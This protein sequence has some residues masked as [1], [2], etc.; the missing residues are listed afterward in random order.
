M[1]HFRV[2]QHWKKNKTAFEK[3]R[4]S[5]AVK[6]IPNPKLAMYIQFIKKNRKMNPI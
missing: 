1:T 3:I 6:N 4:S 2:K 5:T